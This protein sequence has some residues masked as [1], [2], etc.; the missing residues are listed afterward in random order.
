MTATGLLMIL[1]LTST[2]YLFGASQNVKSTGLEKGE[3]AHDTSGATEVM[4]PGS[5]VDCAPSAAESSVKVIIDAAKEVGADTGPAFAR[6]KASKRNSEPMVTIDNCKGRIR[7]LRNK[8]KCVNK[9][10]I[11][12]ALAEHM[13]KHFTKCAQ[14][15]LAKIGETSRIDFVELTD[16]G[17]FSNRNIINH[18]GR[19]SSTKS[20]HAAARAVD[21]TELRVT[22]AN[23]QKRSF[24]V[25]RA[26][27]SKSEKAFETEFQSCWSTTVKSGSNCT[28]GKKGYKKS[29]G[30]K[31]YYGSLG[32]E[33]YG[34]AF[35]HLHLSLPYCPRRGGYSLQ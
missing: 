34:G 22:L 6:T 32:A 29:N 10:I 13:D 3:E 26:K 20:L 9:P 24:K 1:T 2:H 18:L 5:C 12:T 15:G 4:A 14:Q 19:K 28:T 35:A 25:G 7:F 23:G 17:I 8:S 27:A 30:Q 31:R 21:F 11:S 33:F 16:V